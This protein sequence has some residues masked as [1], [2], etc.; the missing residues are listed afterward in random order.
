MT[1]LLMEL[2]IDIIIMMIIIIIQPYYHNIQNVCKNILR[3]F[4]FKI[5]VEY[6]DVDMC[7]TNMSTCN[8]CD[9]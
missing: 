2:A 5:C 7:S 8:I 4:I 6:E 1:Q 9:E 3:M